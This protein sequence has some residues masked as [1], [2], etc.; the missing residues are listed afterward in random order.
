MSAFAGGLGRFAAR[1]LLGQMTEAQKREIASTGFHRPEADLNWSGN[2]VFA[3]PFMGAFR[4]GLTPY[5]PEYPMND[6]SLSWD[7]I[8]DPQ[9]KRGLPRTPPVASPVQE[10]SAVDTR[11]SEQPGPLLNAIA[12]R[13]KG[14]VTSTA[15]GI[16]TERSALGKPF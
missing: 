15:G 2:M 10:P 7:D 6:P 8:N 14:P 12:S 5:E 3:D 11:P 1:M 13:M 9:V 16:S 4:G